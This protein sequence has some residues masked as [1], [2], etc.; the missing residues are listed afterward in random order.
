VLRR[1]VRCLWAVA[2][3]RR[4]VGWRAA[5]ARGCTG[6]GAVGGAA[7]CVLRHL[8]CWDAVRVHFYLFG[9]MKSGGLRLP[10]SSYVC[11]IEC[12]R[13]RADKSALRVFF[14]AICLVFFFSLCRTWY[15][16]RTSANVP[17]NTPL[18]LEAEEADTSQIT[19][20]CAP[21]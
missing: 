6:A 4:R 5:G 8:R 19:N 10:S 1:R 15:L 9:G 21:G 16:T 13:V 17:V 2:G 20:R 11:L 12:R 18:L 14:L 7:R 3:D